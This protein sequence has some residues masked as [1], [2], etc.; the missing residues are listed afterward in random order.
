MATIKPLSVSAKRLAATIS[1]SA[2]AFKLDNILTWDG[3]TN[4]AA[5][6]LGTKAYAA[7]R[8]SAGTLVEFMEIDPSTI[9]S[10][11]ITVLRRGLKYNGD[12]LT[13]EV[14]ANKLTWV[15]GD[16]IVELGTH[17]P[18]LLAHMVTIVGDQS[19]DGVKTFTSIPVLPSTTP[20][21]ATQAASKAYVDATA[22][23]SAVYDQNLVS[24]VAG[25]T[26]VAG[27]LVYFKTADGRWWKT[28]ADTAA[29]VN[30]V[31][32]GFAQ[33]GA[34]AAASVNIL[35]GGI[36]KN[37]SGLTAGTDYS[38]SNTAGGLSSSAGTTARI[39]GKALTTTS[40]ILNSQFPVLPT[41]LEKTLLSAILASTDFYGASATGNDTYVVT[42]SPVPA[43]LVSGLRVRFKTDV[44]NTGA[45]TLNV[46]SLGA[47]TIKKLRD[48]DL[49]TGDIEA[50]QIVEVVYDG[51][52]FQMVSQ[53]A[54]SAR[55][56]AQAVTYTAD[57][58]WTKPAGAT[59]VQVYLW[60]A[61]GG[62][63]GGCRNT[64]AG[65]GGGGGGGAF[66]FKQYDAS[67]LSATEAVVVGVGGPGGVG[68]A[69]SVT[70]NG[71]AGT[72]GENSTFSSGGNLITSGGGGG[73]GGGTNA[74]G[75]AAG[76]AGAANPATGTDTFTLYT[77]DGGAGGAG[78]STSDGSNAGSLT[79]LPASGRGG[80]GGGGSQ[81][82]NT[83]AGTGGT[84]TR[85]TPIV[86]L[87]FPQ[88]YDGANNP[89]I[90]MLTSAGG[91]GA[92]GHGSGGGG[93]SGSGSAGTGLGA[94]GGGAGG[95]DSDNSTSGSGSGGAGTDGLVI[96]VTYF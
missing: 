85:S 36:D 13:T 66:I 14:S 83:S 38:A 16:T 6:D 12:D 18:Q 92:G 44:A 35:I 53:L 5:S 45:A 15:K 11:S 59:R 43:A 1:G 7:F 24:G 87:G 93:A 64:Q 17:L 26:L 54:Q 67:S 72:A 42:L 46:N 33:G 27:N 79:A 88:L 47:I 51:T 61:G 80:G 34:S 19:I 77:L 41:A 50:G 31:I 29:T 89:Y 25:E 58:T 56:D 75:G 55:P 32:F 63:G 40:I 57:G 48:Q 20:T 94:G 70:G 76:A 91:A 10:A 22:T 3:V 95:Q 60:G 96:V 69:D 37:Q 84:N 4:L 8:N 28:D 73:G 90:P 21:S 86:S 30:G 62:G 81:G 74:A 23:G 2:T 49:A 39:V 78:S 65:G 82:T 68:V 52:N 71:T 9:A